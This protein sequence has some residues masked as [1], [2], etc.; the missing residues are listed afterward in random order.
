VCSSVRLG[1]VPHHKSALVAAPAAGSRRLPALLCSDNRRQV[2]E[3]QMAR[4]LKL[5]AVL[6]ENNRISVLT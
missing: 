1:S 3:I 4:K 5:Q 6:A 2:H